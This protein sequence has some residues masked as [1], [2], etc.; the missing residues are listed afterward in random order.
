M[1][2]VLRELRR[3]HVFRNAGFY[4]VGAWVVLQVADVI[5]EPAGL[6]A[7]TMTALLYLIIAVFPL[8][9]YIGWRYDFTDRGIVRTESATNSEIENTDLSLN[10]SDYLILAAFVLVT[11]AVIYQLLPGIQQQ[12]TKDQQIV[13]VQPDILPNSIAVLPFAD[14]SQDKD[15]QYLGDGISDTVMHVLSRVKGLTVTARTSSFAFKDQN[16][17][18]RDIANV[19]RVANVLEGSVQK[20][21]NEVRIIARLIEA[22]SGTELWSGYFDRELAGIFEIQ[23]EIAREVVAAL[24][25]ALFDEDKKNLE[26]RYQPNLE[27]YE[28]L[29]LGRA[30]LDRSTTKSM[31]AAREHFEKAIELDPNFAEPYVDLADIYRI[32]AMNPGLGLAESA[33]IRRTYVEKAMD[34]DPMSAAAHT[35]LGYILRDEGKQQESTESFQ[36][37]TEIDPNHANAYAGLGSNAFRRGD[38]Q[39]SLEFHKKAVELDPQQNDFQL[40]LANAYWNLAQ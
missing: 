12:A 29:I 5:A 35:G 8:A 19:L 7:W 28:Q 25:I 38:M 14:I 15:Q 11:G 6:P 9:V 3:R 31:K 23:D 16:L 39:E 24:K 27:S 21:E 26:N 22:S 40:F 37:A 1:L 17:N 33:A 4:L 36:R 32:P 2:K 10:T 13:T 30:E 34:L 20:D 18:V